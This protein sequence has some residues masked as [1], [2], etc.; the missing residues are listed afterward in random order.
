MKSGIT[1]A[2]FKTSGNVLLMI[3]SF[4]RSISSRLIFSFSF[5]SIRLVNR[6]NPQLDFGN[7]E[8]IIFIN[9]DNVIGLNPQF[10]CWSNSI[11][12]SPLVCISLARFVA[13][14]SKCSL[15]AFA[16]SDFSLIVVSLIRIDEITYFFSV[17]LSSSFNIL[18]FFLESA[19]LSIIF[20]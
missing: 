16:T 5:F 6:S 10:C 20:S 18:H 14:V 9:S 17:S 8:S 2:I 11:S 15:N 1:L 12:Q 7:S 19:P 13:H 4:I 3:V